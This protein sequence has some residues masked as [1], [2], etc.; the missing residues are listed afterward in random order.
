LTEIGR[1][2]VIYAIF[3]ILVIVFQQQQTLS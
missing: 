2:D 3:C 1:F